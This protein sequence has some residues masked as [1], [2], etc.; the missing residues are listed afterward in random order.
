MPDGAEVVLAGILSL[1]KEVTTRRGEKMGFLQLEDKEG[2]IEMVAFP[3]TYALVRDR[4]HD[5]DEPVVVIGT[6][7]NQIGGFDDE[8]AGSADDAQQQTGWGRR[9][10]VKII[11]KDIIDIDEAER[12]SIDRLILHMR[13]DKLQKDDLFRLRNLIVDHRGNCPVFLKL[14]VDGKGEVTVLLGDE[15]KVN[16]SSD[17]LDGLRRHF[18]GG[19]LEVIYGMA[20][21]G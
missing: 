6:V 7:Q 10:G 19:S 11:V 14:D 21:G 4:L 13:T 17:L 8:E 3:E 20:C 12:R 2:L 5:E 9:S 15:Y 16:P 1:E 18:G